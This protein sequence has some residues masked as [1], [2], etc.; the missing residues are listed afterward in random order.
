M[1]ARLPS[2]PRPEPPLRHP[3][4]FY[5]TALAL[6]HAAQQ[7]SAAGSSSVRSMTGLRHR[8]ATVLLANSVRRMALRRGRFAIAARIGSSPCPR[9]NSGLVSKARAMPERDPY[10]VVPPLYPAPAS[11][12]PGLSMRWSWAERTDRPGAQRSVCLAA[13]ICTSVASTRCQSRGRGGPDLARSAFMT[14]L[15]EAACRYRNFI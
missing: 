6:T 13:H 5:G 2:D 3:A 10:R 4:G 15:L 14:L 9:E 7:V 8:C 11:H 12:P 1:V